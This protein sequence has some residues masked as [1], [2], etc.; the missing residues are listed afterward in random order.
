MAFCAKV[1]PLSLFLILCLLALLQY[2]ALQ[3]QRKQAVLHWRARLLRL[4]PSALMLLLLLGALLLRLPALA[5]PLRSKLW[6]LP[7]ALAAVHALSWL[8]CRIW[9]LPQ[10]QRLLSLGLLLLAMLPLLG[11]Y[12]QQ[13]HAYYL[14]QLPPWLSAQQI[15]YADEDRICGLRCNGIVY[16]L[17]RLEEAQAQRIQA[18][19]LAY[20]RQQANPGAQAQWQAGPVP[21]LLPEAGP[22]PYADIASL[23]CHGGPCVQLSATRQAQAN[24]IL[25][26]GGS[27]YLQEAGRL[28]VIAPAQQMVLYISENWAVQ[29]EPYG[30]DGAPASKL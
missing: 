26:H 10:R 14:Q 28:L 17:S 7:L 24:A 1:V 4:L 19:G 27:F 15:L 25:Q 21:Q 9:Q 20:L 23:L 13:L 3:L 18:Q 30:T 11:Y 16:H 2:W 29:T 22:G 12:R 8:L 5:L 6:L